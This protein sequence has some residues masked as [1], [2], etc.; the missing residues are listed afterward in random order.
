MEQQLAFPGMQKEAH[1]RR[2]VLS[3][4]KILSTF[5]A[6]DRSPDNYQVVDIQRRACWIGLALILQSLNEI[7]V[8]WYA[9]FVPFLKP[10]AGFIPFA[11][12]AGSFYM[13]WMAFRP[14]TLKEQ[15]QRLVQ[16]PYRWQRITLN[17]VLISTLAG[18]FVFGY[19]ISQGFFTAP[20]YTNDG[21]SLDANAA[22]ELLEGHNP[23]ENPN[24]VKIV[25]FFKL[26]PDWTT[27]LRQGQF[28]D[29]LDYPSSVDVRSVYDTGGKSGQLPEFEAKVSYPA[30]SFLTL[31]PFVWLGVY[32]VLPFYLLCYIALVGLGWKVARRELRPWI[33][34]FAMADV[35]MWG[36]VVGGNL[37]V[38]AILL[39]VV[40]WLGRERRWLSA[41]ALGLAV[42]CKQPT[43]FYVPFYA[44]LVFRTHGWKEMAQRLLIAGSLALALNLP[45]ILWDTHAWLAGVMA[46]VSDPMFP[47][48]VGIVGLSGSPIMPSYM[49]GIVYS[50]LEY[51]IFYPL[52]LLW[53][54][55]LCRTRPEAAMLL[56]VLPL[57]F[58]WRSLPSYFACAAFPMFILLAWRGNMNKGSQ[59]Y[60]TP[61]LNGPEQTGAKPSTCE[62]S[63]QHEELVGTLA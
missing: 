2:F 38:L 55:R 9:P 16:H 58:A 23:Y 44:I 15:T 52:C 27:P 6:V 8:H 28:A 56:A 26:E 39:V 5:F 37:D 63:T 25:R 42:A 24:L 62:A 54:W 18:V 1:T 12:I 29:R 35:P 53:Y 46:P 32:N 34:L 41:L 30:L 17:L 7:N 61:T 50:I 4:T 45:F 20:K 21:T 14:T 59:P 11:L 19:A 49:P 48:G 43:W 33:I 22:I 57:F 47:M 13:L 3:Q 31:V 40:A 36:S 10:W 51:G 60:H